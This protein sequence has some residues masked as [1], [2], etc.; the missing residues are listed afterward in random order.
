MRIYFDKSQWKEM[1][2]NINDMPLVFVIFIPILMIFCFKIKF[3][4]EL[5]DSHPPKEEGD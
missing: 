3:R 5:K 1:T 4:K 2:A